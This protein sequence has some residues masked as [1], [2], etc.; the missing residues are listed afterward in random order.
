MHVVLPSSFIEHKC[1]LSEPELAAHLLAGECM[2]TCAGTAHKLT[3]A[4][5]CTGVRGM[6]V[7]PAFLALVRS[8]GA[9]AEQNAPHLWNAALRC[10]AAE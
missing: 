10:T 5:A 6:E 8:S 4:R 1:M 9:R 7:A 3:R 2:R